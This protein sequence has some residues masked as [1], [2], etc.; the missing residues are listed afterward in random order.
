MSR[1]QMKHRYFMDVAIATS[2]L[3]TCQRLNV[4]AVVV[5]WWMILWTWYNWVARGQK[6][7]NEVWCKVIW[8]HC[9]AV[10]SEENAI[11]NCAYNGVSTKW[12]TIYCTHSPCSRCVRRMVNAWIEQV[13]FNEPYRIEEFNF[14]SDIIKVEH[15]SL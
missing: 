4:W 2:K 3:S 10:H 7:C 14:F 15:L 8:W 6:H 1:E 12:A 5:R 11:I 13:Y 9:S